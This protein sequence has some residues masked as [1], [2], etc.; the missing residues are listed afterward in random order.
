MRKYFVKFIVCVITLILTLSLIGCNDKFS[1]VVDNYQDFLDNLRQYDKGDTSDTDNSDENETNN[2]FKNVDDATI[3]VSMSQTFEGIKSL[4]PYSFDDATSFIGDY[5][6]VKINGVEFL[7]D[8]DGELINLSTILS[9]NKITSSDIIAAYLDKIVVLKDNFYGLVD[10]SGNILLSI[11]YDNISVFGNIVT[12][13]Q[14][15]ITSIY[16]DSDFLVSVNDGLDYVDENLYIT[17]DGLCY[18]MHNLESITISAGAK[19]SDIPKD[20]YMLIEQNNLYGIVKYPS[21]K[22]V[23]EP[24]Y[25]YCNNLGN[26]YCLAYEFSMKYSSNGIYY[27]YPKLLRISDGVVIYDFADAAKMSTST[28]LPNAFSILCGNDDYFLGN[29]INGSAE[30][31]SFYIDIKKSQLSGIDIEFAQ[32]GLLG[33][34][35]QDIAGNLYDISCGGKLVT[36]LLFDEISLADNKFIVKYSEKYKLLDENFEIIVDNCQDISYKFGVFTIKIN[37]KYAYYI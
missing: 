5:A 37:N 33:H 21:M 27:D 18:D 9:T 15:T 4:Y 31:R 30:C 29:F 3:Y 1:D 35:A 36:D 17:T 13:K 32:N 23:I 22:T 26:G 10:F 24:N 8:K 14:G 6:I 2:S 11:S 25:F 12:A 16:K 19:P 34:Y 7:I 20:G 28:I